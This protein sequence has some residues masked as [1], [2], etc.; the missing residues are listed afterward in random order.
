MIAPY[1][2]SSLFN[3]FKSENKSQFRLIKDPNS[4]KTN[5]FKINGDI[6]VTL[7]SNMLTFR[8]N[9]EPFKLNGD[10]LKDMT[11]YKFNADHSSPR[12]RTSF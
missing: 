2:A 1:L 12:D 6:P 11:S 5:D 7:Y 10:L 3:L 9:N 4:T 8:D